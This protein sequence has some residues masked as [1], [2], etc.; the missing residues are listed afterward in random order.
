MQETLTLKV[1]GMTCAAC[2]ARIEKVLNRQPGISASV[3]FASETALVRRPP[4]DASDAGSAP[5]LPL[6]V[7]SLIAAVQKAGFSAHLPI[8]PSEP[9]PE[10]PRG[11]S[12]FRHLLEKDGALWVALLCA[13]PFAV[14]MTTML[15]RSHGHLLPIAVQAM[16]ATV[17]QFWCAQRFY[18][19][20][21]S[22]TLMRAPNMDVLVVTGSLAAY[23]L[24]LWN[25]LLRDSHAVYFESGVFVIAF[26]L[27]GKWL[28][29]R[30]KAR[31]V[32]SL[33]ALVNQAPRLARVERGVA[34]LELPV[35]QVRL[36]DIVV[37]REGESAAVDGEVISGQA[38]FD[39]SLLTGESALLVKT[40]GARVFAGTRSERGSVRLRATSVGAATQL[41]EITRLVE[42]AQG[43]KPP[44][45]FLVDR[46]AAVFVP[47]I[48]ALAGLTFGL[49]W[50]LLGDS[51]IA[52]LRAVA[53]LVIACPCALGLATPAA[54]VAGVGAGA[55]RGLLFRDASALEAT[56]SVQ[57]LGIDKTGTL[58]DGLPQLSRV[59]PAPDVTEDELLALAAAVEGGSAH[60]LARA[61]QQAAS[62]RQLVVYEAQ[63]FSALAG[64]GVSA[65]VAGVRVELVR[66]SAASITGGTC[67][68]LRRAG[69]VLGTLEFAHH[70]RGEA[71]A[72]LQRLTAQG[73]ALTM[74]TGDA[75]GPAAQVA[76]QVGLSRVI[77]ACTPQQKW[78]WVQ[79]QQRAG[80]TVA[81][82]G[83]GVNDAPALAAADLSIAMRHGSS[84]ALEVAAVTL[85]RDNLHALPDAIAL[86]RRTRRVIRSNLAFAFGY[87]AIG[88]PLAALGF[89][90]PALAGAAMALSSI[91]VLLNAL[92][93]TVASHRWRKSHESS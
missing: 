43:S 50:W 81:M 9:L 57:V 53:V 83:D 42:A 14:D 24:S 20:A 77:S 8:T 63:E 10:E 40:L 60:P 32:A 41:A 80:L 23:G 75:A 21:W 13:L 68:E 38:E 52:A 71:R 92:T 37:V 76:A 84:A 90:S 15:G 36:D 54:I 11:I 2:A 61:V 93:L 31:A 65:L 91:S 62:A 58:T 18:R 5:A 51:E 73:V 74:L 56:A 30:A 4:G 44:V 79:E 35:S 49:T 47:F 12:L 22:A 16:L 33:R 85:M 6:D 70:V 25:W 28:E 78:A 29:Q 59:L 88:I 34:V 19:A 66:S 46:I 48:L 45:Q 26:V 3:N 72:A 82:V 39:E 7:Q 89:L 69:T 67:V 86:A 55:K 1:D 87:N 17:V 64:V 27:L